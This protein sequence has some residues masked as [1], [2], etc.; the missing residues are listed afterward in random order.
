MLGEEGAERKKEQRKQDD[1]WRYEPAR[2]P[3]I[4]VSPGSVPQLVSKR[5]ADVPPHNGK[6]EALAVCVGETISSWKSFTGRKI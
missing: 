3:L 6:I 1:D 4:L 2:K 5:K